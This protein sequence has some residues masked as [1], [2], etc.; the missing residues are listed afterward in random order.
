MNALV[1]V[2]VS[3]IKFTTHTSVGSIFN[4]NIFLSDSLGFWISGGP[5][6]FNKIHLCF[7]WL[8]V[9]LLLSV[10]YLLAEAG[11]T[12]YA[13]FIGTKRYK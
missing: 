9:Y 3:L 4:V 7:I 8:F 11:D 2:W 5:I 10:R 13:S 12:L 1:A 6:K